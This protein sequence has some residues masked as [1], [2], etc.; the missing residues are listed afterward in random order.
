LASSKQIPTSVVGSV[1]RPVWLIEARKA[2][3][4]GELDR[5]EL[6]RLNDYAAELTIKELEKT[7]LDEIS[8]GEQR[9]TNFFEYLT[10]AVEGFESHRIPLQFGAETYW[11]PVLTGRIRWQDPAAV[12]ELAFS[13]KF[14][15][16]PVK[17][18]LPAITRLLRFYPSE[19]IPQYS[20]DR[21]TE[22]LIRLLRFEHRS[23]LDAGVSSI[24]IDWP[25]VTPLSSLTDRREASQKLN[26]YLQLVNETIRDFPSEKLHVHICFGNHK[27]THRITGGS[28]K[29][30]FPEL[31][32]LKVHGYLLE[33]ANPHHEDDVEIF[34]EYPVPNGKRI[35]A[36]LIDVKTPDVEP[37]W[38]VRKRLDRVANFIDRS[39]LGATTD[40]GFAP[41]WY[42]YLIPRPV[43]FQKLTN[44]VNVVKEFNAS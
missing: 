35:Y 21:F 44:L 25:D 12:K 43:N 40:C 38:L 5:N 14:T 10:E 15:D 32:D 22:D 23:L 41:G 17:V 11:E 34:K 36:G 2:F 9:R 28:F 6:N 42:S 16:K 8:D 18:A 20:R 26:E 33:L 31:Y 24:Q 27:A 29:N 19:G 37:L 30:L 39:S 4:R 1:T 7:G 3:D 13:K